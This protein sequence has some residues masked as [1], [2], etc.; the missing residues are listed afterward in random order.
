MMTP[1]EIWLVVAVG[2]VVIEIIPPPTHFFFLG[3]ALGALAASVAA[4]FSTMAWLPWTVF[5][6]T[7]VVLIPTLIP[8]AKFLFTPR[9]HASNVDEL[10]NQKALVVEP[11]RPEAPGIVKIVGEDWRALSEQDSFEKG[12]W[13]QVIRVEGTHVIIRRIY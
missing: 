12:Q 8:L 1:S 10:I 2:C 3:L 6:V 5:L 13:G 7:S 9:P 11:V 4:Y